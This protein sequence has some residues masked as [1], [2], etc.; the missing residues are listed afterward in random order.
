LYSHPMLKILPPIRK[1]SG[2]FLLGATLIM[3]SQ[4]WQSSQAQPSRKFSCESIGGSPT[5]I[6]KTV[7]GNLPLIHWVRSFTGKYNNIS[8]RCGEV[9]NRLDRFNR[10]GKLKYI[11]TGNV[12]TYPV[13]CVDAGVSGNTCP[14][15]SVLVT[16]PK[17]TDSAQILQQMLDLRARASGRIIQLSGQQLVQYRNRDAYVNIDLLLAQ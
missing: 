2:I 10:D 1:F 12:N 14:K 6:V 16:L 8:Q 7:R 13:L 3:T 4:W 11:R 5:T 15:S 17:G 9:S